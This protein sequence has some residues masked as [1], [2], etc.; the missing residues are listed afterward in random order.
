MH[1]S[2][3]SF[4]PAPYTD[5]ATGLRYADAAEFGVVLTLTPKVVSDLKG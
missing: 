5:A 2:N 4:L 1:V 3:L